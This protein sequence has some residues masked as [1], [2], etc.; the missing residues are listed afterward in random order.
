MPR[1]GGNDT[2]ARGGTDPATQRKGRRRCFR[3]YL[4]HHTGG[5][6]QRRQWVDGAGRARAG[7]QVLAHAAGLRPAIDVVARREAGATTAA[8]TRRSTTPE[9]TGVPSVTQ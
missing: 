9:Q 6:D 3:R 8:A 2:G 4:R 1:N 7:G 5:S